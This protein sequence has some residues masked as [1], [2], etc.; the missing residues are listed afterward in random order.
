MVTTNTNKRTLAIRDT[1]EFKKIESIIDSIQY[2]DNHRLNHFYHKGFLMAV[3]TRMARDD[4]RVIHYLEAAK[5]DLVDSG[6][7]SHMTKTQIK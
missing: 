4:N 3:M 6:W 1:W 2:S 5:K 7:R